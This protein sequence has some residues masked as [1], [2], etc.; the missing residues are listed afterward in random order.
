MIFSVYSRYIPSIKHMKS[1]SNPHKIAL[2]PIMFLLYSYSI[3]IKTHEIPWVSIS[4]QL[5]PILF[6]LLKPFSN[7]TLLRRKSHPPQAAAE[8]RLWRSTFAAHS[9]HGLAIFIIVLMIE[10]IICIYYHKDIIFI[11]IVLYHCICICL[12]I[13]HCIVLYVMYVS[14]YLHLCWFLGGFPC[15]GLKVCGEVLE[16]QNVFGS[17]LWYGSSHMTA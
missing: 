8:I 12:C 13:C 17:S 4:S 5:F 6:P 14:M 2:N 10:Y 15:S 9:H 11:S 1:L 7:G 3:P 16:A